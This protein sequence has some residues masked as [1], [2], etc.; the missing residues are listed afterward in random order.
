MNKKLVIGTGIALAVGAGALLFSTHSAMGEKSILF[1][2]D[3]QTESNDSPFALYHKKFPLIDVHRIAKIGQ[4][5]AWAL[6]NLKAY[7][8]KYS[9]LVLFIGTN[10]LY[11]GTN[12]TTTINNIKAIAGL[13]AS[14]GAKV[15]VYT[16][17][18]SKGYSA[19]KT[20]IKQRQNQL[21]A[22]IKKLAGVTV[23]DLDRNASAGDALKTGFSGGDHLHLGAKGW[24]S[25]YPDIEKLINVA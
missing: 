5:S 7:T 9:V 19:W 18:G 20:T 4:Q 16:I 13:A 22:M 24:N 12:I 6:S 8:G 10:D 14:K 3:S 11:A 23:Y 17:P 21:N 1:L 25:V 2:G 15:I